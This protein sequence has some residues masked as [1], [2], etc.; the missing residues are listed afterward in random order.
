MD[1]S[2]RNFW[3]RCAARIAGLAARVAVPRSLPLAFPTAA[4]L[5]IRPRLIAAVGP[6]ALFGLIPP[7]LAQQVY[8]PKPWEMG[9]QAAGG[10][11]KQQAIDLHDLVL[12]IIT[13]IT[14]FVAGLLGWVMYRYNARRN[15]T[16]SQTSHNTVLEVAWTVVP[17]LILVVMAIP[18]F[19]LVYYLDRTADADLTVKVTGHQWYWEYSYPDKGNIDFSSYIIPDDQLK[20]D[21]L[22]LLTVDNDLVVPAGKNIR[23]LQT[24]GDV[25]HSFFIPSLGVQRY[26]IPGRTI[27]TWFRADK[28]GIY[29]GECN[30]ICGTNHSRMPIVVR[31]VTPQEFDTWLVEAKTKYADAG[32]AV[33]PSAATGSAAPTTATVQSV[34]SQSVASQSATAKSTSVTGKP[35]RVTSVAEAPVAVTP[36][37]VTGEKPFSLLA[38]ARVQR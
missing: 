24:S 18:S 4:R 28:P 3:R 6:I 26:A 21:Q 34:A 7:A 22:R 23:V 16:P 15:P 9:M 37:A 17:I 32:G 27:E 8:A 35:T 2:M 33:A 13:L 29:L 1:G 20:P 10:P 12:V 36:A 25:I 31:A 30:Q 19:R 38:A 5:A 11:L 14:L